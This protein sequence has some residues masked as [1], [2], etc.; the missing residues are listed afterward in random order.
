MLLY[1]VILMKI[2]FKTWV[3]RA[4]ICKYR[5]HDLINHIT[6]NE[7]IHI[8]QGDAGSGKTQF[9]NNAFSVGSSSFNFTESNTFALKFTVFEF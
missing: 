8:L 5:P 9:V 1:G 7:G 3:A 2:R 6:L 4:L